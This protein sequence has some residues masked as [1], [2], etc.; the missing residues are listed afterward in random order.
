MRE[1]F[2]DPEHYKIVGKQQG[3]SGW[4]TYMSV[5]KDK[6][7]KQKDTPENLHQHK[8]FED[9]RMICSHRRMTTIFIKGNLR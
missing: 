5:Y 1:N 7:I 6:M 8:V 3:N 2:E 9:L 4:K